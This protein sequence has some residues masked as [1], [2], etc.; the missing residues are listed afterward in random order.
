MTINGCE[1]V[2]RNLYKFDGRYFRL[3]GLGITPNGAYR[4]HPGMIE[5]ADIDTATGR[6]VYKGSI[7]DLGTGSV[8]IYHECLNRRNIQPLNR[9][10]K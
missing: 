4:A 1:Q 8:D 5:L 10:T 7:I 2:G 6:D 9:S 3:V